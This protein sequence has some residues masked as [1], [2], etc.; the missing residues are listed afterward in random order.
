MICFA[1]RNTHTMVFDDTEGEENITIVDKHKN[2]IVMNADGIEITTEKTMTL[3]G[4]EVTIEA[5]AQLTL[6]GSPV[7]INP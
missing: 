6:K 5:S 4:E 1:K 7:H 2:T 3:K